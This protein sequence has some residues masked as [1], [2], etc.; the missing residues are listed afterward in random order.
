MSI[1]PVEGDIQIACDPSLSKLFKK[2]NELVGAT[3]D[4]FNNIHTMKQQIAALEK[5]I[6]DIKIRMMNYG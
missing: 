6:K 4:D 2:I 5:E 1:Q 3:N